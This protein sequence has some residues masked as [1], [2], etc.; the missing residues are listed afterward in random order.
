M[1]LSGPEASKRQSPEYKAINPFGKVPTLVKS[2]GLTKKDF[3]VFESN[4][5]MKYLVQVCELPDHWY[6]TS[7]FGSDYELR[8]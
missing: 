2:E 4:A 1:M 6:P 7:I 3:I 5:I 8:A